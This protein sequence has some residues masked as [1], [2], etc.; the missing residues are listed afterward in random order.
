M[1]RAANDEND[2][3]LM[4]HPTISQRELTCHICL[5]V[6]RN[7]TA[8]LSHRRHHVDEEAISMKLRQMMSAFSELPAPTKQYFKWWVMER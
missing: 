7:R 6:H 8:L 1:V 3:K 2:S 4:D 5:K